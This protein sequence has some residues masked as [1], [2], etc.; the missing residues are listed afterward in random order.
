MLK[1]GII[2]TN[3][4][5]SQFVSAAEESGQYQLTAVYSRH[6][7]TAR[8]FAND[9]KHPEAALFTDLDEFWASST[10]DT[11]YIASPNSLHAPQA[12]AAIEAGK[13]AI[14]E[15]P[16]V[17]S[18]S[19]LQKLLATAAA[20]PDVFLFEAA[21][22]IYERNFEVVRNFVHQHEIS[23]A[24][25]V[26]MKYSSRYDAYLAGKQPNVFTT[27]FAGGA[28]MDLGVYVVYAALDWFGKPEKAQYTPSMLAS[29][30]DGSG[31]LHLDYPDF[32]VNLICG[33]TTQSYL[34]SEIYT[35]RQT[36]VVNAPESITSIKLRG[37]DGE[38]ELAGS[39]DDNPMVPEVKFFA[40][41][42]ENHDTGARDR[43]L[44][45]A[46]QVHELMIDAR[47]AAGIH[48]P[49]DDE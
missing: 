49:A 10:F 24:T 47:T 4:I 18:R 21:R 12:E 9:N 2:G 17:A 27:R 13:N 25:L 33:K 31:C 48:F 5:T 30:V 35:G 23:G 19:Q 3:W 26:Y 6:E 29:G 15:K 39:Q 22:H 14:V 8:K 28:L 42:I 16:M 11:V 38:E 44:Q 43:Q 20:H 1:L 46:K 32:G 36:L 34:A 7:D 40:S 37:G 41:A 45:L